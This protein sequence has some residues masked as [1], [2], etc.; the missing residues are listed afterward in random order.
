MNYKQ[1]KYLNKSILEKINSLES[2]NEKIAF[3]QK[4]SDDFAVNNYE[5]WEGWEDLPKGAGR[6]TLKYKAYEKGEQYAY[7]KELMLAIDCDIEKQIFQCWYGFQDCTASGSYQVDKNDNIITTSNSNLV[8]HHMNYNRLPVKFK[9]YSGRSSVVREYI[10]SD[11]VICCKSCHDKF[12]DKKQNLDCNENLLPVNK[13]QYLS[14][15]MEENEINKETVVKKTNI[16]RERKTVRKENI[17]NVSLATENI[18]NN[19]KSIAFWLVLEKVL[20]ERDFDTAK[21]LINNNYPNKDISDVF[22]RILTRHENNSNN[23]DNPYSSVDCSD[24]VMTNVL[25]FNF[26]NFRKICGIVR[27][28][29]SRKDVFITINT[30]RGFVGGSKINTNNIS[31]RLEVIEK[32]ILKLIKHEDQMNIDQIEESYDK[33]KSWFAIIKVFLRKILSI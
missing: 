32:K 21:S 26:S 3:V 9:S 2:R 28:E 25:G 8:I 17:V 27:R 19:V 23:K 15:I 20:L 30:L 10:G 4:L 5:E 16:T 7:R 13:N 6:N 33:P 14:D 29:K 24:W 31:K 18:V 1:F 11:I 12:K 22:K